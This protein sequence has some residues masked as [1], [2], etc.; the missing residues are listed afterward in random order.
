MV[1]KGQSIIFGL[2]LLLFFAFG[3]QIFVLID[4]KN[5]LAST[6]TEL[7]SLKSQ[8]SIDVQLNDEIHKRS[9]RQAVRSKFYEALSQWRN[10]SESDEEG[11][12]SAS[13]LMENA[14]YKLSLKKYELVS[15]AAFQTDFSLNVKLLVD[16]LDRKETKACVGKEEKEEPKVEVDRKVREVKMGR[17]DSMELVKKDRKENTGREDSLG[18][19]DKKENTG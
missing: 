14:S 7:D 16:L 4:T 3:C 12:S 6:K 15:N 11:M 5:D 13:R 8:R 2:F 10:T 18:L 19:Q 17:E 1:E 9:S